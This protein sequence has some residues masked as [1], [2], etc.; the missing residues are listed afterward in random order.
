[1]HLRVRRLVLVTL[2]VGTLVTGL[3]AVSGS[4]KQSRIAAA[5]A[6]EVTVLREIND[7]R[8][9]RGLVPL[10]LSAA[11][12]TAADR[13]SREMGRGGFFG[14]E[15]RD[16]SR[17]D[18]RVARYYPARGHR[19]WSVGENLVWASP[20]LG[21]RETL[22]LWMRSPGHRDNLLN[23]AWR[24]IGLGAV[25]V[26]AAPGVYGGPD[27]TLVTADFGVRR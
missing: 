1:M 15:S 10:R 6:L 24:E 4:A 8:R 19:R 3:F 22:R 7:A 26:T 27:V 16:G 2:V 20:D 5:D 9:E 25:H 11:L 13:H 17:F 14:H 12:A 23:P 21:G 18:R